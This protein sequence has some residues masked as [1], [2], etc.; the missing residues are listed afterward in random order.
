MLRAVTVLTAV[1]AAPVG[2]LLLGL[3]MTS[4]LVP[5]LIASLAG[6]VGIAVTWPRLEGNLLHQAAKQLDRVLVE[7]PPDAGPGRLLLD[8]T[9]IRWTAGGSEV[10][11]PWGNVRR[12]TETETHLFL[13]SGAGAAFLVPKREISSE[14]CREIEGFAHDRSGA[15]T[16]FVSFEMPAAT[17]AR[18]PHEQT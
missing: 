11:T 5:V 6:V 1:V 7:D 9:G 17:A 10:A 13:E 2:G 8:D 12:L 4:D 3:V 16:V 18:H 14:L 15:A